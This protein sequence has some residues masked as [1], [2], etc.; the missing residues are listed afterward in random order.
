MFE[1]S[2]PLFQQ[3][4]I[5]L[6]RRPETQRAIPFVKVMSPDNQKTR[7]SQVLLGALN[8]REEVLLEAS[9]VSQMRTSALPECFNSQ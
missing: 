7:N 6:P 3:M 5:E 1:K 2:F 8:L 4:V 9:N